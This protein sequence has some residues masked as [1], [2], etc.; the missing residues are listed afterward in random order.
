MTPDTDREIRFLSKEG[1]KI[2]KCIKR[3]KK[4][5]Q[6]GFWIQMPVKIERTRPQSLTTRSQDIYLIRRTQNKMSSIGV[7]PTASCER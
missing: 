3:E 2:E 7:A 4:I 5:D 6:E 1:G